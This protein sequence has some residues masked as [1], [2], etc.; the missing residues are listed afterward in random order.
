MSWFHVF[1]IHDA[2]LQY[3]YNEVEIS[4]LPWF[5]QAAT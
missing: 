3:T 4:I 2:H 5:G 1:Y